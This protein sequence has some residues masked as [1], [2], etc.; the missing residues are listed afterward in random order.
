MMA[1]QLK[2][3]L[4]AL[5]ADG[6][7]SELSAQ[8][9]MDTEQSEVEP[10]TYRYQLYG[11]DLQAPTFKETGPLISVTDPPHARKTCRNQPQYGTHTASLGVGYLV[12]SS[13]VD[14]SRLN[15]S[16]LVIRDVENVDKQDDGA[17]RRMFHSQALHAMAEKKVPKL[18][19]FSIRP[20]FEG[21]FVYLFVMGMS[22][23]ISHPQL[24]APIFTLKTRFSIRS[25]DEPFHEH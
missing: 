24:E 18:E 23:F 7:A 1:A 13:L 16:G 2:I 5:T 6:A 10:L 14:L 20:Q 21:L 9:L 25:M 8:R 22:E 3:P 11:I 19:L 4:V 15:G 17:A 12:N